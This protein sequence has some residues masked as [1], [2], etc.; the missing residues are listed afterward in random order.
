MNELVVLAEKGDE[1]FALEFSGYISKW[2]PQ[3]HA[4]VRDYSHPEGGGRGNLVFA[5]LFFPK[6]D[7]YTLLGVIRAEGNEV[8]ILSR[9]LDGHRQAIQE[10]GLE[11]VISCW[12]PYGFYAHDVPSKPQHQSNTP[13]SAAELLKQYVH[14]F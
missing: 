6:P 12:R 4:I 1:P 11:G 8:F 5:K 10:L 9:G 2:F 7:Y 14:G 13:L 3:A